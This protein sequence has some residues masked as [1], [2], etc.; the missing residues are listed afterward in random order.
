M[1]RIPLRVLQQQ[2]FGEWIKDIPN[3]TWRHLV[4]QVCLFDADEAA[5][6][7][8]RPLH[9][10]EQD[11]LMNQ[12]LIDQ[13]STLLILDGYDEILE[14]QPEAIQDIRDKL[15]DLLTDLLKQPN[16]I[17]TSRPFS[18]NGL[19]FSFQ[20]RSTC[21]PVEVTGFTRDSIK[22]Y[23]GAFFQDEDLAIVERGDQL[24]RFLKENHRVLNSCQIPIQ[25]ELV[26]H[27]WLA[28]GITTSTKVATT[29]Q[30]YSLVLKSLCY[31]AAQR[32]GRKLNTMSTAEALSIYAVEACF[33]DHF[34]YYGVLHRSMFMHVNVTV[35]YVTHRLKAAG[36]ECITPGNLLSMQHAFGFIKPQSAKNE[37]SFEEP[38]FFNHFSFRDFFAARYFAQLWKQPN[39][40]SSTSLTSIHHEWPAAN[41]SNV[42]A[43]LKSRKYDTGIEMLLWFL[44]GL[45]AEQSSPDGLIEF[46]RWLGNDHPRD[47]TG[48]AVSLLML[49]CIDESQIAFE[50]IDTFPTSIRKQLLSF[51]ACWMKLILENESI[52]LFAGYG[53]AFCQRAK[54]SRWIMSTDEL[55]SCIE[56][57]LS[58]VA[59][60]Q[61]VVVAERLCLLCP[62]EWA[63]FNL[64]W[65]KCIYY[66][67]REVHSQGFFAYSISLWGSL[68][69]IDRLLSSYLQAKQNRDRSMKAF[70]AAVLTA[71]F[72]HIDMRV[73]KQYECVMQ[74]LQDDQ[75]DYLAEGETDW[76]CKLF[77]ELMQR[78]RL[79]NFDGSIEWTNKLIEDMQS[80]LQGWF[81][82][83]LD[84]TNVIPHLS[85]IGRE[86]SKPASTAVLEPIVLDYAQG[87]KA[88]LK[89][90][91]DMSP[92]DR[93]NSRSLVTDAVEAVIHICFAAV[94]QEDTLARIVSYLEKLLLDIQLQALIQ[95]A[96]L[97]SFGD[98]LNISH[99][100]KFKVTV[101][102]ANLESWAKTTDKSWQNAINILIAQV[103]PRILHSLLTNTLTNELTACT[104]QPKDSSGSY[105][106]MDF[107]RDDLIRVLNGL[108]EH[109]FVIILESESES[110]KWVPNE[111]ALLNE[112]VCL[113]V[114]NH[115]LDQQQWFINKSNG[116]QTWCA[117]ML[118]HYAKTSRRSADLLRSIN[119]FPNSDDEFLKRCTEDEKDEEDWVH[120]QRRYIRKC[121]DI[122][123]KICD[124]WT[125]IVLN[126][127]KSSQMRGWAA[128]LLLRQTPILNWDKTL[129]DLVLVESHR[130]DDCSAILCMIS[131]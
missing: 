68:D 60:D 90:L 124:Y 105:E 51:I 110:L 46:L 39:G 63:V 38:H 56:M 9:A 17:L 104:S 74:L 88:V 91:T 34:A 22:K 62:S 131:I 72:E 120:T 73:N 26:C 89:C 25:S 6:K 122:S 35:E 109:Y 82:R 94:K 106:E 54:L 55:R 15:N 83:V 59:I 79:S 43:F 4:L 70:I 50:R 125:G 36:H 69:K 31:R 95:R 81:G 1:F 102:E 57:V 47:L 101:M 113:M 29:T 103:S 19:P 75:L 3:C 115:L 2:K 61:F 21:L 20:D 52:D 48:M 77:V 30:L 112:D 71:G 32:A 11:E 118:K 126:G 33:L 18:L 10:A 93:A 27:A 49:R 12:L 119:Q 76:R 92:E 8:A 84:K 129:L 130:Y 24:W 99:F 121:S 7:L 117:N 13:Q 107:R 28:G 85:N 78:L 65:D 58:D 114:V 45:L 67:S 100:W 42:A 64:V 80:C 14:I 40:H 108:M 53:L 23:I 86:L 87:L 41:F 111:L 123:T 37:L 44:A 96:I 97:R 5:I 16:I 128:W 116:I 127:S 98:Y 66:W